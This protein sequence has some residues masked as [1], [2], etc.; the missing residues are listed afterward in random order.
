MGL[1]LGAIY[2]PLEARFNGRGFDL[3]ERRTR[4]AR[5]DANRP[6]VQH[7]KVETDERGFDRYTRGGKRVERANDDMIRGSA[8]LR[9]SFSSLYVGGAGIAG[10]AGSLYGFAKA[11]QVAIDT[12][13]DI[14][15]S[16]TKNQALF[17][18]YADAVESFSDRSA[19]AFGISKRSALEYTGVF[20]NLARAQGLSEK[21]S[22]GM[23]VKLTKLA[24]DLA[25]FNNTSIED[26][27]EALR[28]GLVGETE[29][30]RKFGVALSATAVQSEAARMGLVKLDKDSAA[31]QI[32]LV[33]VEKAEKARGEALKKHGKDSIEARD[34]TAKL[35]KAQED[36]AKLVSGASAEL[37]PQQKIL[38][39]QSLIFRQTA[40]AQGDFT[41]TSGGLA[42]QTRIL[43]ARLSDMSAD[44]GT[45]LLPVVLD[46]TKGFN[47][48]IDEWE[49]GTGTGGEIR[50][51]LED[52]GGA[53]KTTGKFMLDNIEIIKGAATAWLS[54]KTAVLV[55]RAAST[56]ASWTRGGGGG[57]ARLAAAE[58]T[59]AAA[60]GQAWG[61]GAGGV[62]GPMTK[63]QAARAARL[64][65]AGRV[66]GPA[67]A[68]AAGAGM[69]YLAQDR[70]SGMM[71]GAGIGMMFGPWGVAAGA[72]GGAIVGSARQRAAEIKADE[73]GY[74]ELAKQLGVTR[75][76]YRGL[77]EATKGFQGA[78]RKAFESMDLEKLKSF[79][80]GLNGLKAESDKGK[81]ALAEFG[82]TLDKQIGQKFLK[83]L[84][85]ILEGQAFN[86]E[87]LDD[88]L[89]KAAKS[90]KTMDARVE[91]TIKETRKTVRINTKYI[92]EEIGANTDKGRAAM[93]DNFKKAAQAV[94]RQMDR[95]GKT[96]KEGLAEVRR[97]MVKSLE[98]SGFT[99]QQAQSLTDHGVRERAIP[100]GGGGGPARAGGGWIGLPGERGFDE[101]PIIVGRGEAVLNRHQQGVIEGLLGEGFLDT[102]FDTVK[103][104]HYYAKGGIVGVPGF[105]GERANASVI[106]M[107]STIARKFGLTLTDAYG[108]G[109][110][111]PG[112]TVTGTAADFWG[113]DSRMDAAVKWLVGRGY[114]VGY[115]G[116]FG[117]QNWPG[118]GPSTKTS[119]AHLH[120]E[121][122]SRGAGGTG[123]PE[124]EI[125]PIKAPTS[126]IGGT[127]GTVVDAALGLSA[128][129][130]TERVKKLVSQNPPVGGGGTGGGG[131]G[132]LSEA[133]AR[134]AIAA[135]LRLAGQPV[136]E[137]AVNTL[138]GRARQESGLN[139]RAINNWDINAKRGD[140]SRGL[141]QTIMATFNRYKV[142]GHNDVYNPVDNTAAAV[143]YML[144]TYGRLVGPSSTGYARGGIIRA[145]TGKK[146]KPKKVTMGPREA[147]AR[148]QARSGEKL[149]RG[150][151][152][153]FNDQ[154]T[155]A[156]RYADDYSYWDRKF[157]M[158]EEELINEETG[159][160]NV[161]QVRARGRELFQLATIATNRYRALKEARAI[162]RRIVKTYNTLI[163]RLKSA[164]SAL[165][166]KGSGN[167]RKWYDAKLADYREAKG[168]YEGQLAELRNS[169]RDA[170]LDAR[171]V[172]K[173]FK[174]V[175]GT[176][177]I[178][179]D[180]ESVDTD[181]GPD[182]STPDT[183]VDTTDTPTTPD[184]AEVAK[185][186]LEQVA[187][188]NQSRA[189]LFS[190]FGANFLAPGPLA[191]ADQ[192]AGA[193]YFGGGTGGTEGDVLSGAGR[194]VTQYVTVN[195]NSDPDPLTLTQT[196]LH[197]LEAAI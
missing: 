122:G 153:A 91:H 20:G 159:E 102:L 172:V 103:T 95:A 27:L 49:A 145:A 75:A 183:S 38:A 66:A 94:Q 125:A 43:K 73:K 175:T 76:E 193:R 6:V 44:I 61:G 162:A 87:H 111:S 138:L 78:N 82:K 140:P 164:R 136:T 105:P 148:V 126:G 107:I 134:T 123:L 14:N 17:G 85:P 133:Q 65:R 149:Q 57:A 59:T 155:A 90:F 81:E 5:Q 7:L 174:D 22:A 143:R 36:L 165:K 56:A 79:R 156:D 28:S 117:S 160:V 48:L 50:D 45:K 168:D 72:T 29:P 169:V 130:A 88:R 190:Q 63:A 31:Y 182:T 166:G 98:M 42:N 60:A 18:K 146:G 15:E 58:A 4:E 47:K 150:R 106:P 120:V 2:V 141:L 129:A 19:K 197:E 113:T 171:E 39:T 40:N 25:S 163:N 116:R 3:L 170:D 24:A 99:S 11:G 179:Q 23:S 9:T 13:S 152:T 83:D 187:A 147:T 189:D 110:K 62:Y 177:A 80:N 108:Q 41:K 51:T 97:L 92:A 132:A 74:K 10:A 84:K 32:R 128:K 34:A 101:I 52:I 96:T 196:M 33:T 195:T 194:Q 37:T 176:K 131:A 158:S 118:H 161:E 104:P 8:R 68:A 191:P 100:G 135:G 167:R 154:M 137:A 16:I 64:A 157:S 188:F 142:K 112:H 30:M 89:D 46:L 119:N 144:A 178:P 115:D 124:I 180:I 70:T 121:L 54:Y 55:A 86:F 1:G 93:A 67:A 77:M 26:A 173:E 109:H 192:I 69:G 181:L 186:A 35:G 53:L 21:A 71:T 12:A 185:A 139:P 114:L 127:L 151:V 184:P